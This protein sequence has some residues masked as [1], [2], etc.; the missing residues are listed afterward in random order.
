MAQMIPVN[1]NQIP[2]ATQCENRLYQLLQDHTNSDWICYARQRIADGRTPDFL[3]VGPDLGI[4]VLEEKG[5]PIHQIIGATTESW[6]VV[7]NG[8]ATEEPHPLRQARTNIEQALGLIKGIAKLKNDRGKLRFPYGHGVVLSNI[9][10]MQLQDTGLFNRSLEKTFDPGFVVCSDELPDD[11]GNSSDFLTRLRKM[12]AYFPFAPLKEEDIQTIRAAIFPESIARKLGD[13][14]NDKNAELQSLSVE[15][16]QI[17]RGIGKNDKFPHRLVRGVVGSG[18]TLVL[19]LRARIV[20]EENKN[21]KILVTFFTR[22]LVGNLKKNMP[23][24]VRALTL[25]QAMYRH[26]DQSGITDPF[27]DPKNDDGWKQMAGAFSD[28]RLRK[29][30]YDAIF[31]D[32]AQDLT[33]AQADCLRG[34]LKEETNVAFFCGDGAQNIFNRRVVWK[35]HGF[36]F[37]GRSTKKDFLINYRNTN[38]IFHFA[39][40]FIKGNKDN[41]EVLTEEDDD[42]RLDSY[43]PVQCRRHGPAPQVIQ[44]PTEDEECSS[45]VREIVRL[46]K[47]QAIVPASIAIIIPYATYKNRAKVSPY[48]MGLQQEKIPIYWLTENEKSKSKYD[49]DTNCVVISTPES[50]KGLE[51]DIV[52]MPSLNA[53]YEEKAGSLR[54]VTATRARE[55]L[56]PSEVL[57]RVSSTAYNM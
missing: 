44:Y 19:R 43:L 45:V 4:L 46:V 8:T 24:N 37:K 6:T 35:N 2:Q 21:W 48:L 56:Y 50:S 32:E 42:E 11:S 53:Y 17:A 47:T 49:P 57:A 33:A 40:N 41:T 28:G 38:Q 13:W 14:I 5:F 23:S 52:F 34:L 26:W 20:A 29:G 55:I 31:L 51:W 12:T 10:R 22:S 1:V 16:E 39:L 7:R 36:Y 3:I 30:V 9:T 25:G 27:P 18:K 15:Q 54:Y